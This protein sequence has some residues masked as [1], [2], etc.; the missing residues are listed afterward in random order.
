MSDDYDELTSEAHLPHVT[1]TDDGLRHNAIG[2]I[3]WGCW[4]YYLSPGRLHAFTEE[5]M[6]SD[7]AAARSVT[8]LACI[9]RPANR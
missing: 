2:Y 5:V 8:C 6:P 3:N 4:R 7:E 9:A 1:T